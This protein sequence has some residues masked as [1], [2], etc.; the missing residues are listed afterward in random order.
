MIIAT[1]TPPF[2]VL[3]Y[4]ILYLV[5]RVEGIE[6]STQPWQGRVLT[7]STIP[8]FDGTAVPLLVI[9]IVHKLFGIVK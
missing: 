1:A 8:A 3:L 7:V 2:G 6:P 4:N 9:V 5:E